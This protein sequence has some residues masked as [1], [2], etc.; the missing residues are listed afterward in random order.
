MT[1]NYFSG[2]LF[3][4]L[5]SILWIFGIHGSNMLEM[6]ADTLL[7]PGLGTDIL[8]KA[9]IDVFALM[10]GCGSTICLLIAILLFSKRKT[11]KKIVDKPN[12]VGV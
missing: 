11:T 5:S 4:L 1:R 8:S 2:L 12:Q 7:V 6:A 9:F 3:I 10:G